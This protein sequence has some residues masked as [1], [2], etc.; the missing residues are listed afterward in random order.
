MDPPAAAAGAP[1]EGARR[2][3]DPRRQ[4]VQA[5]ANHVA[6]RV[7]RATVVLPVGLVAATLLSHSRRGVT[8]G[9]LGRR[10][11]LL[12]AL[13]AEGGARFARGLD[14]APTDPRVP[15]PIADA[16]AFLAEDGLVKTEQ[17]A[18]E[19]VYLVPDDRR[20]QLDYHRNA[21]LHRFVG[22][23]LLAAA[24]R[25]RGLDAPLAEVEEDARFLSRLLKLEF[26]YRVGAR[27]DELFAET[28]ASLERVGA[29]ARAGDRLRVGAERETLEFLADLTRAYVESYQIAAEGLVE[30]D[31]AAPDAAHDRRSLVKAFLER[32]RLEFLAGRVT[33]REA[34]SR[35]ALE[36]AVEWFVQE[37]ALVPS[38]EKFHVASH[39]RESKLPALLAAIE[40]SLA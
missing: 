38:G 11:D 37:G 40:R 25:A 39:W 22:P 36:N 34:V 4:L 30:E 15:G 8:A 9:D 27:F 28:V 10:V 18:G 1:E 3:A 32:G 12:R 19:L 5:L 14:R 13:A 20:A 7:Q 23:S 24:L 33:Q 17:A 16:I 6:W 35:P 26:M 21:V 31:R 2:D 29:V